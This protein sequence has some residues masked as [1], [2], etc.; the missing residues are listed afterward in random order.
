M[1]ANDNASH[2]PRSERATRR[3]KWRRVCE[4]GSM[5]GGGAIQ[6]S[7]RVGCCVFG[8]PTSGHDAD[9]V[10]RHNHSASHRAVPMFGVGVA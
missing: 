8:G 7:S 6:C 2:M 4:R 1:C 3:E 5:R 9:R 10:I